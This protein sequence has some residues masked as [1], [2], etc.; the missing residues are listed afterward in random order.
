V[1]AT[2]RDQPH[3][4]RSTQEETIMHHYHFRSP[5]SLL[6]D[7][8]RIINEAGRA[9]AERASQAATDTFHPHSNVWH[10]SNGSVVTVEVPG[11]DP[12]QLNVSI[13]GTIVTLTYTPPKNGEEVETGPKPQTHTITLPF[14][15]DSERSEARYQ[16]GVLH[17]SLPKLNSA[18]PRTIPIHVA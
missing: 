2:T 18:Q 6:A 14:A 10:H 17:I 11:I 3:H 8:E 13:A 4:R 7:L 1:L 12:R 15:A 5:F 16:H 9:Q